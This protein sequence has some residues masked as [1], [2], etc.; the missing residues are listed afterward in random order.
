VNG[1]DRHND[2]KDHAERNG[3]QRE[4]PLFVVE[5]LDQSS[6]MSSGVAIESKGLVPDERVVER[7]REEPDE[8]TA[9]VEAATGSANP[10]SEAA[11]V[12]SRA[13]ESAPSSIEIGTEGFA[14][15]GFG[16]CSVVV[17]IGFGA[18]FFCVVWVFWVV[19]GF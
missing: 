10:S 18:G 3:P 11:A 13:S 1:D 16:S 12:A 8:L 6:S 17:R 15:V 14:L 9:L 2:P 7:E 19:C 5:A 4:L